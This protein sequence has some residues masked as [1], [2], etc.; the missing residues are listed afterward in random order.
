MSLVLDYLAEHGD[1]LDLAHHGAGGCLSGVWLTPRFRASSHTV[2]LVFPVGADVPVLVA[3]VPRLPDASGAL[4]REAASLARL[5]DARRAGVAGIPEIVAFDTFRGWPILVQTALDGRAWDRGQVRRDPAG[6][7]A[8]GLAWLAG[9]H[10]ATRRGYLAEPADFDRLVERPL[11]DLRSAVGGDREIVDLVE[12]T[13]DL[14]A[15]LRTAPMP[16]GMEHGDFSAPNV[17]RLRAGGVG[18]VDWELAD[19]H[20]LPACDAFFWLTYVAFARA[21][22]RADRDPVAAWAPAFWG[23]APWG[24]SSVRAHAAAVGVEPAWLAP[25]LAMTWARYLAG[26]VVRLTDAAP[27][28]G[29]AVDAGTVAWLRAHRYC[30]LWRA[31]VDGAAALDWA[32]D[33]GATAPADGPLDRAPGDPSTTRGRTRWLAWR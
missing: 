26:I 5:A 31:S 21:G 6:A 17:M 16:L 14:A 29:A 10:R 19:P 7:A 13:R 22:R 18:V 11:A 33:D 23:P 20:G 12:R 1:R 30:R 27:G 8:A 32:A 2:A 9:L 24:R 4:A 3:K 28:R 15:P 25:L